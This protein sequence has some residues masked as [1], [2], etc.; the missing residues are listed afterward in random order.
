MASY[1]NGN[2]CRVRE[3][4]VRRVVAGR[5]RH[6]GARAGDQRARDNTDTLFLDNISIARTDRVDAT[7][8]GSAPSAV[9]TLTEL[10]GGESATV[11]V[12]ATVSSL[13]NPEIVNTAT[14]TSGS[15]ISRATTSDCA[16]C[17]DFGDAPASFDG[18]DP[19]RSRIVSSLVLAPETIIDDFQVTGTWD[20][21]T[22]TWPWSATAWTE[23]DGGGPRHERRRIRKVSDLGDFS[24]RW[25]ASSAVNEGISRVVGDL[26]AVTAATLGF[27]RRCNSMEADD[28]VAVEIRP[29]ATAAWQTVATFQNCSDTAYVAQSYPL[30][31]GA[32]GSATELRFR[33]STAFETGDQFF[34]DERPAGSHRPD[35]PGDRAP[36]RHGGRPGD[37]SRERGA[38]RI[39]RRR[40]HG[41]H[42]RR[43]GRC[44]RCPRWTRT[45]TPSRSP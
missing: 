3:R 2:G 4:V 28:V 9:A 41:R 12:R 17:F 35:L 36:P 29:N 1:T 45:R 26:S 13:P 37:R 16:R 10:L 6:R 21:S 30:A 24:V 22:G 20:G 42:P 40:R 25:A 39:P 33:V 8:A 15:F 19:G 14:A 38:G 32:I 18:A 27:Q 43:R 11:V 23:T 44:P 7:V 31:A 5:D 34:L